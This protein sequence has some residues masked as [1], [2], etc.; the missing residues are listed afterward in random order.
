MFVARGIPAKVC[1]E[2]EGRLINAGF[3]KQVLK[4]TPLALNHGGK[5]GKLLW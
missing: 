4:I 5:A 1:P 2:L 3:E